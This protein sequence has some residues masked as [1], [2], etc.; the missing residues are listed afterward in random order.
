MKK[1][2]LGL[3][4]VAVGCSKSAEDEQ[5]N[6]PL[7]DPTGGVSIGGSPEPGTNAGGSESTGGSEL[8]MVGAPQAGSSSLGGSTASGGRPEV[9]GSAGSDDGVEET[10]LA[11][12]SEDLGNDTG[13]VV[14]AGLLAY[15]AHGGSCPAA[16]LDL[17]DKHYLWTAPSAGEWYFTTNSFCSTNPALALSEPSCDGKALAQAEDT[18]GLFGGARVIKTMARGESVLLSLIQQSPEMARPI[19][20]HITLGLETDCSDSIDNDLDG[21]IDCFDG[22]CDAICFP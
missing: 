1:L 12:L 22:D 10:T 5:P 15:R 9:G 20:L 16:G 8:E 21:A 13:W 17:N 18:P 6:S 19:G 4:V 2:A 3:L 11:C 7:P 14:Q